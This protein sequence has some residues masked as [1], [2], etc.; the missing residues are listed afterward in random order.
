MPNIFDPTIPNN[1]P[2]GIQA[3]LD[4]LYLY[5]PDVAN[6]LIEQLRAGLIEITDLVEE[7]QKALADLQ[8]V[9]RYK[10]SVETYD[11]LPTEG[12]VTGDVWNVI[13]TDKNYA[14]DGEKWDEFG[15]GIDT[16]VFLTKTDASATYIKKTAVSSDIITDPNPSTS[17][18]PSLSLIRKY[19]VGPTWFDAE[20]TVKPTDKIAVVGFNRQVNTDATNGVSGILFLTAIDSTLVSS[21]GN[22]GMAIRIT[23]NG[24][25]T[26]D[27]WHAEVLYNTTGE[28]INIGTISQSGALALYP[29]SGSWQKT[30]YRVGL[31]YSSNQNGYVYNFSLSASPFTIDKEIPYVKSPIPSQEGNAGKVLSTNGTTP[32]WVEIDSGLPDQTG[33]TGYLKTDGTTASWNN[34]VLENRIS[35]TGGL[36]VTSGGGSNIIITNSTSVPVPPSF[37]KNNI[38]IGANV[39]S[40]D[41]SDSISIG[42]G[43]DIN[44]DAVV[45]GNGAYSITYGGGVSIGKSAISYGGGV[46]IGYSANTQGM[47]AIAIGKSAKSSNTDGLSI[48]F[49]NNAI[50]SAYGAIALGAGATNDEAGTF[51][52]CVG[53]KDARVM[54]TLLDAT[55]HIPSESL[56]AGGTTGQVLSKTD[57]G[58]AWTDMTGGT[59][60]IVHDDTLAGS[61]T[62][63][64]PLKVADNTYL[65]LSGGT[66]TG[67]IKLDSGSSGAPTIGFAG[68]N[69]VF[70]GTGENYGSGGVRIINNAIYAFS[71]LT[72][73]TSDNLCECVYTKKLNNGS[74]IAVPNKAGTMALVEDINAAVGDIAS[75]LDSI[76]GESV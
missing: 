22:Y 32:E 51:K 61:G 10:G 18:V 3:Q 43:T 7:V 57:D 44:D 62:A 26:N 72:I 39:G 54:A 29:V 16:S 28:E 9:L 60:E 52:V 46:T 35:A 23:H 47:G 53:N 63:E 33:Q 37:Y 41:S 25:L 14:W 30:K 68:Q 27:N 70:F 19:L 15:S 74:N 69:L 50:V 8:G 56:V 49:G 45:I 67:A 59:S 66:L 40:I 17:Q 12:N 58:M 31:L 20:T 34:T 4:L 21:Y 48:A 42:T 38:K 6:K 1:P 64:S 5:N 36:G 76:N 2:Q 65:P 24:G 13:D 73:G 75:V 11:D 71:G 55:G